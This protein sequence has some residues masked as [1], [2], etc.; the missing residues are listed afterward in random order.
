MANLLLTSCGFLTENIKGNF[1][2]LLPKNISDMKAIIIT[3]ASVQQKERNK[4][5]QK[6]KKDFHEMGI[7]QVDFIDIE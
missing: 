3:T 2:D 6:A 5:I 7:V 1:L 4:Y